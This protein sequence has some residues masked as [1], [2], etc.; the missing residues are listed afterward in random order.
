MHRNNLDFVCTALSAQ[1]P[2]TSVMRCTDP[3]PILGILTKAAAA[4]RKQSGALVD[5]FNSRSEMGVSAIV[6]I[7]RVVRASNNLNGFSVELGGI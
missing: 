7:L 3:P 4:L 2:F 6:E 1:A 5:K